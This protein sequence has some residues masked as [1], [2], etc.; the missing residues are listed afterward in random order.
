MSRLSPCWLY[1]QDPSWIQRVRGLLAFTAAVRHVDSPKKLEAALERGPAAVVLMDLQADGSHDML[2]Y[3]LKTWPQAVVIA[4]GT[5]GSEP[6]LEADSLGVYAA[7]DLHAERQRLQALVSRAMDHLRLAQEN[8][9][10]QQ[11]AR[12]PG[13]SDGNGAR[14][15]TPAMDTRHLPGALRHFENVGSLAQS[16]VE[17][18]SQS[19]RVSRAGIFCRARDSALYKLRAGLR[20]LE[21][22][23]DLEYDER[24]PLARWFA[25]HAHL[26]CRSNLEHIEDKSSRLMLSETLDVLGAEALVPLQARERLLG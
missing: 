7:E 1:S 16:F 12:A 13:R 23:R 8:R 17:S 11:A 21:D 5:P 26:V 4:L 2:P 10:L 6:M 9:M 3:L 25:L 18:V 20:C 14:S 24:D 22:T 19:A 15:E